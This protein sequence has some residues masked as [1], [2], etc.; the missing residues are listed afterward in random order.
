MQRLEAGKRRRQIAG[1]PAGERRLEPLQAR[2]RLCGERLLAQQLEHPDR[3][4]EAAKS[5]QVELA[6][7][8][9]AL[10]LQKVASLIRMRVRKSLLAAS[11][12]APRWASSPITV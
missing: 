9:P 7:G 1:V 3:L 2:G 4:L 5:H 12:R 8:D 10:H 6:R 11:R